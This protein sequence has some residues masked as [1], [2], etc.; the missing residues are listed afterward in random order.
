M[1]SQ[2]ETGGLTHL[3]DILTLLHQHL[4]VGVWTPPVLAI[5]RHAGLCVSTVTNSLYPGTAGD[6]CERVLTL[7]NQ[8]SAAHRLTQLGSTSS[9]TLIRLFTF[10]YNLREIHFYPYTLSNLDI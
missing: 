5:P 9:D 10:T 3:L 7:L 4:C 6:F 2:T 8:Y 1:A